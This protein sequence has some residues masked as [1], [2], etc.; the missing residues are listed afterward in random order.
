MVNG[1][2]GMNMV[3]FARRYSIGWMIGEVTEMMSDLEVGR[4][5]ELGSI[6]NLVIGRT[7]FF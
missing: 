3:E 4:R 5:F 6:S 1:I 2:G 7:W